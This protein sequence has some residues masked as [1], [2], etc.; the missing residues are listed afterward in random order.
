LAVSPPPPTGN[1]RFDALVAGITEVRLAQEGLPLPKWLAENSRVALRE[2]WVVAPYSSVADVIVN[3]PE[4][5]RR[6]GVLIDAADLE[7]V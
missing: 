3:T 5:L 1:D 2:Q 7:S 6:R 4:P